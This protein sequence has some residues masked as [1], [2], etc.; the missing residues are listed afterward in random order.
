M[1]LVCSSTIMALGLDQKYWRIR[2]FLVIP[3]VKNCLRRSRRLRL[4][5]KGETKTQCHGITKPSCHKL[6]V[7]Y[8]NKENNQTHP[9]FKKI[10]NNSPMLALSLFY[11]GFIELTNSALF[12][13]FSSN[14]A[15]HEFKPAWNCTRL[16]YNEVSSWQNLKWRFKDSKWF[17]I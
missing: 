11:A 1:Q 10:V 4:G 2:D 9:P 17:I 15:A 8:L 7:R 14:A 16:I 6:E 3:G 13:V 12:S 5:P